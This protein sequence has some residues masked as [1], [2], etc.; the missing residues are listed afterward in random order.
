[1]PQIVERQVKVQQ[2]HRGDRI[3]GPRGAVVEA[4]DWKTKYVYIKFADGHR[5]LRVEVDTDYNVWREEPTPEELRVRNLEYAARRFREYASD[6]VA[7]DIRVREELA[8][9]LTGTR[10]VVDYQD[11]DKVFA[12]Q[13]THKLWA[14]VVQVAQADL[15]ELG[16]DEVVT[17]VKT[18]RDELLKQIKNGGSWMRGSSRSTSQTSNLIEDYER[19]AAARFFSDTDWV[20]YIDEN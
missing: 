13:A 16:N 17:A 8:E 14:T 18:V 5:P 19:E 15:N 20:E 12:A 9:K 10:Y 1:M 3:E 11:V 7:R 2:I 6:A 4:I